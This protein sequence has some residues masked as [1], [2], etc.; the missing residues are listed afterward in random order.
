MKYCQSCAM[1]MGSD[2]TKGTNADKS[3]NEDYCCYCFVDGKFTQNLTMDEMIEHCAQFV[4]EFNKD[5]DHRYTKEE[6]II[7]MKQHFPS[8]KRWSKS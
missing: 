1:P 3:L 6:A 7:D 8:L 5:S 4:N 2:E